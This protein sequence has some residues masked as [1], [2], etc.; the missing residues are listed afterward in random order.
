TE[1]IPPYGQF[2]SA[3]RMQLPLVILR[4]DQLQFGAEQKPLPLIIQK[5]TQ[6]QVH[7]WSSFI[8]AVA[9]SPVIKVLL[10]CQALQ[11][12]SQL[13]QAIHIG[14]FQGLY[15]ASHTRTH[16]QSLPQMGETPGS[17]VGMPGSSG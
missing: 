16:A 4:P 8:L 13:V 15:I 12:N 11:K 7:P 6:T 3:F 1:F 2:R 14:D 5:E 17:G 9:K 10:V